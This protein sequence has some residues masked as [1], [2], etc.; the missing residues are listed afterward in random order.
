MRELFSEG[1][2]AVGNVGGGMR[3]K[4]LSAGLGLHLRLPRNQKR[5]A[6]EIMA[7]P[8]A[9]CTRSRACSF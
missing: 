4:R 7:F 5:D 3:R 6:E 8:C 9:P 2:S 1:G